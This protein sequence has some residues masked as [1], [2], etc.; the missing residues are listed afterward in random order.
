MS[1]KFQNATSPTFFFQIQSKLYEDIAYHNG[2]AGRLLL[3]LAM[4]QVF[5][6]FMELWNFNMGVK[7]KT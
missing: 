3:F 6:K 7:G 5:A 1:C 2:N 4:S